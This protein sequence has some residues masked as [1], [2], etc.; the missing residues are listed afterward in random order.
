MIGFLVMTFA[1]SSYIQVLVR[2]SLHGKP[3]SI[4]MN[5]TP[6][7]VTPDMQVSDLIRNSINETDQGLYP[8]IERGGDFL[9][10][11]DLDAAKKLPEKEWPSHQISEI[12][13]SCQSDLKIE[14]EEDAEKALNRMT[15]TGS[16]TLLVMRGNQLLGILTQSALMRYL[17]L[18]TT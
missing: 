11:V 13:Q 16:R 12:V 7:T 9:G 1:R 18:K 10:C 8:V 15:K 4:F 2:Q 14:P 3:A 6:L 5:T 17:S